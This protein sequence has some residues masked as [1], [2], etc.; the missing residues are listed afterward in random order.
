MKKIIALTLAAVLMLMMS[1]VA[2][3][4]GSYSY[5]ITALRAGGPLFSS[6]TISKT[7][8]DDASSIVATTLT[9]GKSFES[10]LYKS[11]KTTQVQNDY[12]TIDSTELGNIH[13]NGIDV[14]GTYDTKMKFT[15]GSSTSISTSG[16]WG[17][18]DKF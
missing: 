9:S 7:S 12:M 10:R 18:L 2:F 16:T 14:S 6:T 4:T 11:D 1:S 15:T 17:V 13:Y 3:A 8:T 5:T